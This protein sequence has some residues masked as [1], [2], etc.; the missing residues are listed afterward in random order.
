[1]LKKLILKTIVIVLAFALFAVPAGAAESEG[2]VPITSLSL[3]ES[4]RIAIENSSDLAIAQIEHE[5]AMADV[6]QARRD[7][8]SIL[9]LRWDGDPR[10]FTYD[11]M[12]AERVWPR[13]AEMLESL[14][15][16]N[17]EF[18]TNML[19]FNVENAYYRVLRAEMD[20]QNARDSLSRAREQLRIVNVSV[21]AG[22]SPRSDIFGA[23]NAVASQE[24]VVAF[25]ENYLR[26]ARMDF[27][28]LVGLPL[29]DVI[30]LTSTFEFTPVE[31]SFNEIKERAMERDILY[32]RLHTNYEIQR[33]VFTV[34]GEFFPSVVYT[35]HEA[36]RDYNIAKLELQE[37]YRTLELNVRTALLNLE[38]ARERF[39]LME[40]SLEQARENY[41]LINLRFE[42]GL[43]TLLEIERASGEIDEAQ[44]QLLSA[45][46]DY[47]LTVTM[48]RHGF[49]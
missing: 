37:V 32:I 49:F 34:A 18:T 12:L 25:A 29:V 13:T 45:I 17:L 6:R 22:V 9:R 23:E 31:F 38:S 27:N 7:A 40:R 41:R 36:R 10:G 5:Q 14:S 2:R 42:V 4:I 24:L 8:R 28:G 33:E 44:A 15:Y 39:N 11:A 30:T 3:E 20:L 46:Y 1:M 21:E 26:Q 43:A 47:N 16:R 35:Y 19:K 48:I